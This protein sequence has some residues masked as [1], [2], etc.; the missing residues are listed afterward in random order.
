MYV[1]EG[2][3]VYFGVFLSGKS[4]PGGGEKRV[5]RECLDGIDRRNG[6]GWDDGR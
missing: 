4:V 6:K 2:I 3:V 5:E 1:G